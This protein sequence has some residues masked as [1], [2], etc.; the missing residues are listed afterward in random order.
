VGAFDARAEEKGGDGAGSPWPRTMSARQKWH[1]RG[2]DALCATI[3]AV[4]I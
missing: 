4:S 2:A 3:S 1:T